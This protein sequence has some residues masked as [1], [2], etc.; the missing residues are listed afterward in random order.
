MK[1]G[2]LASLTMPPRR[3]GSTF[4]ATDTQRYGDWDACGCK[5]SPIPDRFNRFGDRG[6]GRGNTGPAGPDLRDRGQ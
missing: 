5:Q 3:C 4:A 2:N 6:A 1:S